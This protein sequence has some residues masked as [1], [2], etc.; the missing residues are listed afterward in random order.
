MTCLGRTLAMAGAGVLALTAAS[1]AQAANVDLSVLHVDQFVGDT[2]SPITGSYSFTFSPTLDLAMGG[3][4][5]TL[6]N[7]TDASSG[8]NV[9]LQSTAAYGGNALSGTADTTSGTLSLDLSSLYATVSDPG[10]FSYSGTIWAPTSTILQNNYDASTGA[11][12]YKW[13]NTSNA[14]VYGT[15]TSVTYDITL[16][17]NGTVSTVPVPAA[18]WLF[19]SGLL[20]LIGVG[21]KRRH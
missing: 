14:T 9:S 2:I 6:F 3:Y 5:G 13:E 19:G 11:F 18:F 8:I 12:T 10:V 16:H 21:G 4:S 17:G 1:T 7:Q 15:P 20:G